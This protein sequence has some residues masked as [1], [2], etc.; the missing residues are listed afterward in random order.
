[1][2]SMHGSIL[3]AMAKLYRVLTPKMN[4]PQY[5]AQ[6]QNFDLLLQYCAKFHTFLI[7]SIICNILCNSAT[8]TEIPVFNQSDLRFKCTA[9]PN[10]ARCTIYHC[11]R[12][13]VATSSKKCCAKCCIV[14]PRPFSLLYYQ[15]LVRLQPRSQVLLGTTSGPW[16]RGL[17]A[18]VA[19][20]RITNNHRR[21]GDFSQLSFTN[22]T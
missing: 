9:D 4:C 15:F 1:M 17:W 13:R 7:V 21:L 18:F 8:P 10:V 16:G 11:A 22:Q 3:R 6:Q 19:P 14:K 2:L 5:C 12:N 20:I